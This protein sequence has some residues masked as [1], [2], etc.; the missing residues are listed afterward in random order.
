MDTSSILKDLRAFVVENYLMGRETGLTD[1]DSFLDS[2]IIDSTGVLE[3][4]A[5]LEESYGF[6][7][8]NEELTTDN[9]DSIS[10]VTA[11]VH[12]KLA[13]AEGGTASAVE[14]PVP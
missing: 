10:K 6:R 8:D 5:Y 12:S 3:L 14:V 7:V 4:V 1:D 9:L 13:R 11:Y 2:G